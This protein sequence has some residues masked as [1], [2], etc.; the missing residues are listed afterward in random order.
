MFQAICLFDRST[1]DDLLTNGLSVTAATTDR[2]IIVI[3]G[4]KGRKSTDVRI[5][6]EPTH[7]EDQELTEENNVTNDTHAYCI[8]DFVA[9]NP[10]IL[11][12]PQSCQPK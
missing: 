8:D 2:N 1:H 4:G 11:K 3:K 5:I 9:A 7:E 12:N 10:P 6:D